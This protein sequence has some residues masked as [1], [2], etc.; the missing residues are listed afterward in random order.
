MRHNICIHSSIDGHVSCFQVLAMLLH[1]A[2]NSSAPGRVRRDTATFDGNGGL[3]KIQLAEKGQKPFAIIWFRMSSTDKN[4]LFPYTDS[5][6]SDA[7]LHRRWHLK[8][9]LKWVIWLLS[10]PEPSDI[11]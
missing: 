3:R 5:V 8:P 11:I 9:F 6:D 1:A 4:V 7:L 2:M 10:Q